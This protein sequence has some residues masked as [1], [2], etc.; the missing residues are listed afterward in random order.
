MRS[1]H[2][3]RFGPLVAA[4][5]LVLAA[6]SSGAGTDT[7][8]GA[9]ETT[10]GS[11]ETTAGSTDTT[12]GSTDTTA[13]G[14]G[15]PCAVD[16]ELRETTLLLPFPFAVP[17][18]SVFVA[19]ARG[20]F[21][22]EG[23]SVSIEFADG[24]ASVVQQVVA[25][26]VEFGMSDPGPVIDAVAKGEELSVPY[27]FQ[28]GLIYGFVAPED[29]PYNTIADLAGQ[30]I[31]VSEATA[32]EV[33]FVE[34]LLA[35]EGVQPGVDVTI[36]ESGGGASTA[37][38]FDSDR[39]VA[40]FSDFFNIIE[41]G[42]EVPLK[43]FDLG[44]FGLY[45][46]ASIVA[47]NSLIAEDPQLVVCLTRA[48][49]RASEFTHAS[50]EAALIAIAEKYPEQVTDPEGFDLLALQETIERT[51]PYEAGGG[52]WGWNRPDSWQGYIDLLSNRGDLTAD[53]D[54]TSLYTNDLIDQTN[55]FDK[56]AERAAAEELAAGG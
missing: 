32:G 9:T 28:T 8:A 56:E 26:N 20:Y 15:Q 5:A 24:S 19:D 43:E 40:Y 3:S 37:A 4:F 49:A 18:F 16:G 51:I 50:P 33:P 54:P 6:C 13:A 39:I 41:L 11:T 21:E 42:F 7:T 38:A 22:E 53:V 45:H 34:G 55:D 1:L 35:S 25:N 14:G 47:Q 27:V 36:V 2:N 12:A 46:A 52:M 17:F 30:T 44:E 31:G 23:L 10:A 29:S 48:M